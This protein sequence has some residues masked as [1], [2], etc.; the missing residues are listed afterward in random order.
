MDWWM[1]LDDRWPLASYVIDS[2]VN[3]LVYFCFI[4]FFLEFYY[5]SSCSDV[6]NHLF[7]HYRPINMIIIINLDLLVVKVQSIHHM[8][9]KVF[10][11]IIF[12]E[13]DT[14]KV[15]IFLHLKCIFTY[16]CLRNDVQCENQDSCCWFSTYKYL[17]HDSRTTKGIRHRHSR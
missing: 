14:R 15:V 12:L 16:L 8:T 5:C 6:N 3:V 17:R 7:F 9:E 13:N 10:F 4:D 11:F 2:I 1:D